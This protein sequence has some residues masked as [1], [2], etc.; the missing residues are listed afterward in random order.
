MK[1]EFF[2]KKKKKKIQVCTNCIYDQDVDGIKFD[3]HGK[4]NYCV[5]IENLKEE[6]GTG[7]QKGKLLLG[8]IFNEIKS[9]GKKKKYDC[10][11]GVSGGTDS[12]FL[13]YLAKKNG[14]RPL[15]V[16][17]DNTWNSEIATMNISRVLRKLKVDLYTKVVDNRE[18]DDIFKSFF[19]AGVPE[20]DG[21]TDLG[22]AAVLYE[23]AIKNNIKYILDGH[24]FTTEGITPLGQNY[25]DGKY[26][27]SIHKMYGKEKMKT[28]PLMSLSKFLYWTLFKKIKRIR[29][30]W[31]LNYSKE[32][33]QNFLKKEF[34][35]K[36]YGGH[37]LENKMTRFVHTVYFPEKFKTDFRN[38]SLSALVRNKKISRKKAWEL[39][40]KPIK[41]KKAILEYFI[42]RLKLSIN[43]YEKKM[44]ENPRYWKDFP[45]YKRIFE[46]LSP[47][48]FIMQKLNLVPKSFYVKYCKK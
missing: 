47:L 8:K 44:K 31:Y 7:K 20:I 35:W 9:N 37:H 11:V 19:I 6:Y 25:F 24:S 10:V 27:E 1:K 38:N 28:Y 43:D 22:I 16:H 12:S 4:C 29:P 42:K 18:M 15:A 33:A 23:A 30:L 13:I 45:T 41:N 34:K 48:F 14:L 2:L 46:N 26:I 3:N 17:Y 36:Y 5:Q 40:N 21:T 32:K 39:Y